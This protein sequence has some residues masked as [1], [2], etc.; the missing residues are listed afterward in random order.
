M[1]FAL[2]S[3]SETEPIKADV[4]HANLM[5]V[6][7]AVYDKIGGFASYLVQ[8][9]GDF[10]YSLRAG[11]AGIPVL[12]LP[13]TYG[14]CETNPVLPKVRGIKGL[15]RILGPK[16]MPI[17]FTIPFYREHCGPLWPF[18]WAMPYLRSF[19]VGF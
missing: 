18:W 2:L 12:L 3:P 1:K 14:V 8:Q 19:F 9:G 10:E 5:W 13:G 15:R 16:N 7:A 11:K 6:P 4:L 17:R